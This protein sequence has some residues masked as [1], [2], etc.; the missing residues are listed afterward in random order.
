MGNSPARLSLAI[1]KIEANNPDIEE[2][3][4]E[5]QDI[6]DKKIRMLSEAVRKNNTLQSLNLSA[7]NITATGA[8]HLSDALCC[9]ITT[10]SNIRQLNLSNNP[11]VSRNIYCGWKYEQRHSCLRLVLKVVNS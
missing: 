1:S 6:G 8:R 2:L 4:L 7:C 11:K 3:N 5:K 10:T 9:S